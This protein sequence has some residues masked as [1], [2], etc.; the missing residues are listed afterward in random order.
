[1]MSK[2]KTIQPSIIDNHVSTLFYAEKQAPKAL[3]VNLRG[4]ANRELHVGM[5]VYLRFKEKKREN[6]ISYEALVYTIN[7]VAHKVIPH[8]VGRIKCFVYG[9]G[10]EDL[11]RDV[12]IQFNNGVQGFSEKKLLNEVYEEISTKSFRDFVTG[13]KVDVDDFIDD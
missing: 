4:L 1:M 12:R 5:Y 8:P 2:T 7:P 3:R 10:I 13:K 9:D 11:E 6:G